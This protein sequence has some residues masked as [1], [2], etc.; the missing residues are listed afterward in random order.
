MLLVLLYEGGTG[1]TATF[2]D[3]TGIT[4]IDLDNTTVTAGILWFWNS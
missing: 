3:S 2:V 1:L 4:T